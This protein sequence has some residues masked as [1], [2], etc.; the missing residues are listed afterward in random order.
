M[1][2]IL[3]ELHTQTASSR[4]DDAVMLGVPIRP[5]FEYLDSEDLFFERFT[6]AVQHWYDQMF[7][8]VQQSLATVLAKASIPAVRCC[9]RCIAVVALDQSN[10][11]SCKHPDHDPSGGY[12]AVRPGSYVLQEK[13]A[14]FSCR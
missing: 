4:S 6:G 5:S 14:I 1:T 10:D 7:S 13:H 12:R 8:K 11:L 2:A 9:R 3:S